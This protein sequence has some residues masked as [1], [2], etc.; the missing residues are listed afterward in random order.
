MAFLDEYSTWRLYASGAALPPSISA[1]VAE[2]LQPEVAES[3]GVAGGGVRSQFDLDC[4]AAASSGELADIDKALEWYA[5]ARSLGLDSAGNRLDQATVLNDL[6]LRV[7]FEQVSFP[8][9]LEAFETGELR[10]RVG[11]RIGTGALRFDHPLLVLVTAQNGVVFLG[12]GIADGQG[13][14]ATDV[15]RISNGEMTI[16]ISALFES[17][18]LL[19]LIGGDTSIVLPA[20][21]TGSSPSPSP[22]PSQSPSQSPTPPPFVPLVQA[23]IE[24]TWEGSGIYTPG[25]LAQNITLIVGPGSVNG[26]ATVGGFIRRGRDLPSQPLPILGSI[27]VNNSAASSQVTVAGTVYPYPPGVFPPQSQ[28]SFGFL[29]ARIQRTAN[30][31]PNQPLVL[32]G[33]WTNFDAGGTV[34]DFT[35]TRTGP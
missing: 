3:L 22:S 6:P 35:A 27:T 2:L 16:A 34:F 1:R 18:S 9:D 26:A 10:V 25:N 7:V 11:Y 21:S 30:D 17:T 4:Q 20:L 31:D 19:G 14:F 23:D 32:T 13:N 29:S 33:Q 12:V 24:G 5:R 28:A 15:Q 8:E